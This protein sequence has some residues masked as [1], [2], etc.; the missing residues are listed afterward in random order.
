LAEQDAQIKKV[1][2]QLELGKPVVK[3]FVENR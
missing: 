3:T 2:A 1:S